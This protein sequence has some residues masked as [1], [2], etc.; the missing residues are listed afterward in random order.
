[1]RKWILD[2]LEPGLIV[3]LR[4]PYIY[5]TR[6]RLGTV[7]QTDGTMEVYDP[8]GVGEPLPPT[9]HNPISAHISEL[10][11]VTFPAKK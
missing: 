2:R 4:G 11:A 9:V 8:V 7:P 5:A 1:M 10:Y 6:G 3:E